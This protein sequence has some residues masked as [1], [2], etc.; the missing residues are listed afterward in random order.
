MHSRSSKVSVIGAGAVGASMAYAIVPRL[1][2][3]PSRHPL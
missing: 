2:R 1:S 3:W